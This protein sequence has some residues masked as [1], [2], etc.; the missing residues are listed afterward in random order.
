MGS[1]GPSSS[2]PG[3]AGLKADQDWERFGPLR[4]RRFT[5]EDG[6]ALILFERVEEPPGEDSVDSG[7]GGG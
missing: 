5:K 6:R 1:E 7:T 4:L 3:E 2:Q